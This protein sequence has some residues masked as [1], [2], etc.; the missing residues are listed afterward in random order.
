MAT[1]DKI[2]ILVVDDLPDKLLAL[3]TVLEELGQ[4][5]VTAR[6]GREALRRLLEHDFAV[7]LLDVNMPD[8]DGFETADADPPAQEA[9]AHADHLRHRLRRRDAHGAGLFAGG[10]RL[11]PV[12]GVAGGA[13][14]QGRGFVDLFRMTEQV[15]A[16]G[17]GARGPGAGAG[18]AGGGG[19]GD[20]AAAIP[21]RG[22]RRPRP[23]RWTRRPSS[24]A[25]RA[26][27]AVPGRLAAAVLLEPRRRP[28][29]TRSGGER[30]KAPALPA[31]LRRNGSGGVAHD[32]RRRSRRSGAA[33]AVPGD[34]AEGAR[35]ARRG[36]DAGWAAPADA[37]R[38]TVVT[39]AED[40]A[41][42]AA[43]ALDN[44]RLVP[45]PAG[46][47]SPQ[48]R[49]PGDA[50]PR[51]AQPPGPD[52]QRRP[53][54]PPPRSRTKRGASRASDVIDRQVQQMVRLVDDLL[55][56]SRIT[57][58]KISLQ[59]KPVDV[60]AVVAARRGNQPAADRRPRA[61]N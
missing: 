36:A 30:R 38:P 42:R 29:D 6:S 12:A 2:N 1:E 55:D 8:M 17:R 15:R 3:E 57:R 26:G 9:G 11:H 27:R 49:V 23:A 40:L 24:A 28:G 31:G 47:G 34:P 52:P 25:W 51:A 56:V 7:I 53:D 35:P 60:A 59:T 14:H 4:N 45:R 41:G 61:T 50:G 37:T 39:L 21:G 58:G 22:Q 44:A 54:P 5:V 16:A 10:R 33:S 13:A 48:E 43:I 19:G 46:A 18:G 20:P 32:G